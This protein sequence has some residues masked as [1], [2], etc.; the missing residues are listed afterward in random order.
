MKYK[1]INKVIN[2]GFITDSKKLLL[3]VS[4]VMIHIIRKMLALLKNHLTYLQGN[5]FKCVF[6]KHNKLLF[7]KK[8]IIFFK[9][10]IYEKSMA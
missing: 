5:I 9:I 4:F 2:N 3:N 1:K 8:N 10:Y 7:F 6:K